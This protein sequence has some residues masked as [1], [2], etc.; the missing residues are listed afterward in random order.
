[1]ASLEPIGLAVLTKAV[2]FLFNEASKF[3]QERRER[4]SLEQNRISSKEADKTTGFTKRE[5]LLS[6]EPNELFLQDTYLEIEHCLDQIQQYRKNRRMLEKQVAM[7]G[8]VVL[9]PIAVQNQL[10]NVERELESSCQKL[11]RLVEET[12]GQEI[13][14]PGLD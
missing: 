4:R 3:M 12:Y 7:Y 5:E 9:A 14:I 2:D 1:M 8:G 6:W 13:R 11:R 10:N